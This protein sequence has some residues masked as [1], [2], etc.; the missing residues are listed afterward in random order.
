MLLVLFVRL[1]LRSSFFNCI[2]NT[3]AHRNDVVND[4]EIV[5]YLIS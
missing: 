3:Q 4:D 1:L 5:S 2:N